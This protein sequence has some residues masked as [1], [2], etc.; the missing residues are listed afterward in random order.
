LTCCELLIA[1]FACPAQD[2]IDG[3]QA[4]RPMAVEVRD[5][6][7]RVQQK[8]FAGCLDRAGRMEAGRTVVAARPG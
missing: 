1:S 3:M 4:G 7:D 6:G 5:L 2:S 8:G